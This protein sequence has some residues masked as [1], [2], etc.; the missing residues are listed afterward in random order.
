MDQD[1]RGQS[2]KRSIVADAARNAAKRAVKKAVKRT[3]VRAGAYIAS[4]AVAA[5]APIWGSIA[6]VLIIISLLIGFVILTMAV[7]CN[8]D[9]WTGTFARIG[10]SATYF[11]GFSQSDYCKA[12]RMKGAQSLVNFIDKGNFPQGPGTQICPADIHPPLRYS[13]MKVDCKD[14]VDIAVAGVPIKPPPSPG[15]SDGANPYANRSLVFRL[16][17]LQEINKDFRVTEA[18]CPTVPH[19]S[20]E[21]YN[22]LAVDINLTPNLA[23]DKARLAKLTNDSVAVGFSVLCEYPQGYLSNFGIDCGEAS[24]T[25]GGH[26]HL[27]EPQ[28][29]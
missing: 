8:V 6:V 26:L 22:G 10:S 18:F 15:S 7:V 1:E 21:H 14:C 17:R 19:S 28:T 25:E 20:P 13:D 23:G 16:Q 5:L 11:L 29:P 24:T 2:E 27:E 12:F 9:T 3:A 4:S